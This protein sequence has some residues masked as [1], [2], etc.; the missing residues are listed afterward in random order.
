MI[1]KRDMIL[2]DIDAY[3]L[4]SAVFL[5][6]YAV[7]GKLREHCKRIIINHAVSNTVR[8]ADCICRHYRLAEIVDNALGLY[9]DRSVKYL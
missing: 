2:I 8:L 9:P 6:E 5:V 4:F 1:D 7:G 3:I